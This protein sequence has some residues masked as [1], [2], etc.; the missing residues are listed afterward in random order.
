[1]PSFGPRADGRRAPRAGHHGVAGLHV[2]LRPVPRIRLAPALG[3]GRGGAGGETPA[4]SS[5]SSHIWYVTIRTG[6]EHLN[7]FTSPAAGNNEDYQVAESFNLELD[8]ADETSDFRK[9]NFPARHIYERTLPA[10]T[11]RHSGVHYH[12]SS[13]YSGYGKPTTDKQHGDLHQW[14]VWHG[15][16]EPWH[17]WDILAGRFVSEFGMEGYPDIRTV[18]YW[19]GGNSAER[20]PQSR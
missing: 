3:R 18:D 9:T 14:N 17:N 2:R 12:R 15:S 16:Q 10:I 11:R 13:P 4:A 1:M 20:Y 7:L 19:M 5:I 6:L 8:Y